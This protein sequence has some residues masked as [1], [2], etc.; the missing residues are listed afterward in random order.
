MWLSDAA[1]AGRL[2]IVQLLVRMGVDVNERANADSVP[3]P[4]G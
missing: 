4:K 2:P 3:S 1:S